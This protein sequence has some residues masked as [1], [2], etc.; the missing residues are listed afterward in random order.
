MTLGVQL[1]RGGLG[2]DNFLTGQRLR[3]RARLL[4]FGRRLVFLRLVLG[5]LDAGVTN[6]GSL[7]RVGDLLSLGGFFVSLGRGDSGLRLDGGGLRLT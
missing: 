2:P 6:G 1:G 4:G 5:L 7:L 3:E